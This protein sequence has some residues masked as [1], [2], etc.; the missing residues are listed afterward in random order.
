MRPEVTLR[1][2]TTLAAG[3][4]GG[5]ALDGVYLDAADVRR[6]ADQLRERQVLD[7]RE[8]RHGLVLSARQHVGVVQLGA[9]RVSIQPKLPPDALWAALAYGLGGAAELRA[10]SVSLA[11]TGSFADVLAALMLDAA[12]ALRRAGIQRAYSPRETWMDVPRGRPDQATLAKSGPLTRAALPC[13]HHAYD[14]DHA[15]NGAVLTGLTL[16]ERV[17]V[18]LRLRGALHRAVQEWSIFTRPL[19]LTGLSWAAIH[20]SRSRLTERY[21]TAHQVAELL[22]EGM[23][24][25]DALAAGA[26][27]VRAHVWNMASLFERFVARF[28]QENLS[29]VEVV[30]QDRLRALYTVD[31]GLHGHRAPTPRP[32]LVIR[33][34][35]KTLAVLDT[36][37]VNLSKPPLGRDIL[38]QMSVYAMAWSA[39]ADSDVPAIVLYPGTEESPDVVYR[40]HPVGEGQPR[41]IILRS[42]SWARASG[43]LAGRERRVDRA[44]LAGQWV[45]VA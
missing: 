19:A 37:Y 4:P 10:P 8:N 34:R 17:A 16:A 25:D 39:E 12:D 5:A 3:T 1:E 43:M 40:L 33:R 21:A 2:W 36:K 22:H 41:R 13:R 9:V 29:G 20:K 30:T 18:D 35:K 38:Y 24:A 14:A 23:G 42:V 28:L 6:V 32:D 11:M 15:L 7:V 45:G 26:H 44:A 27:Q 31:I